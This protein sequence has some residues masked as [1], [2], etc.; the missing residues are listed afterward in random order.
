VQHKD[1]I[2]MS[3]QT[4]ETFKVPLSDNDSLKSISAMA[5]TRITA[6][7]QI[8][9]GRVLLSGAINI[10]QT[11]MKLAISRNT[12]KSYIKKYSSFVDDHSARGVH[13]ESSIPVFK[14]EYPANNRYN[15]LIN[16]LPLLTE[17]DKIISAKDIW[18]RYLAIYPNGYRRSAFNLHFSKWAKDSKVTLRNF[19]QVSDIPTEDLKILK[20]WRNSADR[21]KWERAVVIMESFNGISAVEISL[22]VDRGADKVC[23]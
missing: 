1:G 10:R 13:Q 7:K 8:S 9:I 23:D 19:S 11:S 18:L 20:R 17:A 2:K 12:V 16:A 21:R 5:N 22:K 14:I 3:W 6:K 15:E 4:L